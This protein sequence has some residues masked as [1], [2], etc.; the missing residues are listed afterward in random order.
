MDKG[1][2]YIFVLCF[3]IPFLILGILLSGQ[4]QV[5]AEYTDGILTA[6]SILYGIWGIVITLTKPN[7]KEMSKKP[8]EETEE[9]TFEKEFER[10]REYVYKNVMPLGFFIMLLFLCIDVFFVV[11]VSLNIFSQGIALFYTAL[12]FFLNALFLWNN[13][14]N[15]V[16][17]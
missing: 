4:I 10:I 8:E 12:T 7:K 13:L 17:Q 11:L 6:S 5:S 3:S 14:E 16:F 1:F 15:L 2:A 9:E